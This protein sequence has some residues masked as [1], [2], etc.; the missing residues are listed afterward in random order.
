MEEE[1]L[2]PS[3]PEKNIKIDEPQQEVEGY[4]EIIYDPF[5]EKTFTGKSSLTELA[6]DEEF[7]QRAARFLE[8]IGSNENI[9][10]NFIS[11]IFF[12]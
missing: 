2:V 1:K 3:I 8:G 5:P 10:E 12:D 11:D 6:N 9:F 7:S 4:K